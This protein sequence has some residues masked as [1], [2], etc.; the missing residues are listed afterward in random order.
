MESLGWDDRLFVRRM[1]GTDSV[2]VTG[3]VGDCVTGTNS[4][5]VA[6]SMDCDT[7]GTVPFI[8][9]RGSF[10][11]DAIQGDTVLYMVLYAFLILPNS[12]SIEYNLLLLFSLDRT[13]AVTGGTTATAFAGNG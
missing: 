3:I 4:F 6:D 12:E 8:I 2:G 1:A 11:T 13:V 7:V 10:D 5:V 9:G